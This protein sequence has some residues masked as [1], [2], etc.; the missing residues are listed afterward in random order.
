MKMKTQILTSVLFFLVTLVA[1]NQKSQ[2][3]SAVQPEAAIQPQDSTR[4]ILA[5]VYIKPGSEADFIAA[6]QLMV[7]N[8]NKEEGCL[9]Y[10]LFQSPYEKTGFIFVEFYKN[11][12]AIDFHF[13]TPYFK[14]FGNSIGDMTSKPAEI[15]I[16]SA[17]EIK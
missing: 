5:R 7:E 14:E 8:S 2:A 1:C 9:S 13:A 15:K 10:Q 6:A 4:M 3:P 11:Q 16:F 17:S 12:A